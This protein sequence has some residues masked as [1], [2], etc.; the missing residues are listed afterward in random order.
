[1]GLSGSILFGCDTSKYQIDKII[2]RQFSLIIFIINRVDSFSWCFT[3][4][5]G[6]VDASLKGAFW[7]ELNLIGSVALEAWVI[8]GDFNVIRF[9]HE[10]SGPNF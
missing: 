10:K 2:V 9:R 7:D 4:V 6:P 8:C 1:M 3:I 5:Y